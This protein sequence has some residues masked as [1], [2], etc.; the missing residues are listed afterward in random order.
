MKRVN[1]CKRLPRNIQIFLDF[2]DTLFPTS[3]ALKYGFDNLDKNFMQIFDESLSK[4]LSYL[5][6]I[7]DH[8]DIITGSTKGWIFDVINKFC[9][10]SFD[11]ITRISI[12]Y[13]GG[14]ST[15]YKTMYSIA[16]A[17]RPELIISIG[18]GI[19]EKE[20]AIK[21]RN[22]NYKAITIKLPSLLKGS[23]LIRL[24]R[25][26]Q[27]ILLHVIFISCDVVIQSSELL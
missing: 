13:L 16:K 26:L 25:E 10:K 5:L 23:D 3:F 7:S 6:T 15:K 12:Y 4:F 24:H 11:L 14:K 27:F 21:L 17:T 8:I 19:N 18:D 2:D 22:D 20:S 1:S 9:P